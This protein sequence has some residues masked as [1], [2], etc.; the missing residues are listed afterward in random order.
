M[1][2]LSLL[3]LALG[4]EVTYFKPL[5]VKQLFA[6]THKLALNGFQHRPVNLAFFL[7]IFNQRMLHVYNLLCV[8]QM[9]KVVLM[10]RLLPHLHN[11]ALA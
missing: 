5:L 10:E 11:I 6:N 7:L 2:L 9:Q 3:N 8:N 4:V 1:N